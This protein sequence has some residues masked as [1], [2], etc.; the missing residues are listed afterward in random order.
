MILSKSLLAMTP[1]GLPSIHADSSSSHHDSAV[2]TTTCHGKT[3]AYQEL[4][5]YGSIASNA[6]D[7]LGDTIGGIGSAIAI[8]KHSWK[9]D[10]DS[11][12]GILYA[13]PDRGIVSMIS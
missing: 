9:K 6:R 3:Y 10:G 1:L 12:S 7:R 8:D 13:L 11:Y 5:G 2:N 4:A